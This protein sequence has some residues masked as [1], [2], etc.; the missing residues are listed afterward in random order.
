M[1]NFLSF[2]AH[3]VISD[4]KNYVG[5]FEERPVRGVPVGQPATSLL[6]SYRAAG[7]MRALSALDTEHE[8]KRGYGDDAQHTGHEGLPQ[9]E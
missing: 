7:E 3:C 9:A 1:E 6:S 8:E 2:L 4:K 5:R